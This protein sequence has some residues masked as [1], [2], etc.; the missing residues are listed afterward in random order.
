MLSA[1]SSLLTTR[2]LPG[3]FCTS[4]RSSKGQN[5]LNIGTTQAEGQNHL[6]IVE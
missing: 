2:S 6:N 1:V 5:H 3:R 4:C